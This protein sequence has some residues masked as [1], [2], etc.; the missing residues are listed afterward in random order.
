MEFVDSL[1][2][3][4][5]APKSGLEEGGLLLGAARE[6]RL[7]GD[8]RQHGAREER[9]WSRC[10]DVEVGFEATVDL[11]Q[12]VSIQVV[13]IGM[14]LAGAGLCR[15]C[16]RSVQA[17]STAPRSSANRSRGVRAASRR[18]GHLRRRRCDR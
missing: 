6:I 14:D 7:G 13:P 10:A 9:L 4:L 16:R 2:P 17:V 1:R 11:V 12:V 18:Q 5:Q 15:R 8:D 3:Y